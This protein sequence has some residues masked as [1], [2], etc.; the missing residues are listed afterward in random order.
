MTL[1]GSSRRSRRRAA[2]RV[3]AASGI[4]LVALAVRLVY[5]Y[6][7][8]LTHD[9]RDHL[10]L[11]RE[12]SLRPG[13]FNLPLDSPATNHPLAAVYLTALAD[14]AGGGNVF[15]IR[16]AFILLSLLGLAGLYALGASTFGP[17]VALL[18]LSLAAVDRHLVT[19]APVFLEPHSMVF[20]VPWTMLLMRRCLFRGFARDWLAAGLLFGVGYWFCAVFVVMLLPFGLYM[21]VTRRLGQVLRSRWTY[22]GVAVMLALIAASAVSESNYARNAGKVGSVGVSPRV[23]L[24]Y[25]GDLLICLKDPTWIIQ[26]HGG[27]MYFPIN[28]P[29]HWVTGLVY[30]AL[31]AASLRFRRD[32][33]VI[34]LLAAIVGV[35]IPVTLIGARE[36]WN[37]FTWASS[38]LFAAILLASFVLARRLPD[39]PGRLLAFMLVGYSSVALVWFLAGPKWGYFCPERE[40]ACVGRVL[41]LD[42]R[43]RWNP[44]RFPME[45]CV[46]EIRALTRR[47]TGRHPRCFSAWYF[48]GGFAATRAER[49]EAF[50]RAL[51]LSPNNVLVVAGQA[52][53]RMLAGDPTGARSLLER[54][55]SGDR[56]TVGLTS[57]YEMAVE[58][59]H[60]T[61]KYASAV[62]YAQKLA[63]MKPED[64]DPHRMLFVNYDAMGEHARAEACLSVYVA[65]EREGPAAAYL[66][67]AEDF[68][69]DE[70]PDKAWAFLERAIL[71]DSQR[72]EDHVRIGYQ[73]ANRL[74]DVH[75]AIEHW[76]RAVQLG[77]RAPVVYCDLALLLQQKHDFARAIGLYQRAIELAP[78]FAPAHSRL[79]VLLAGQNRMDEAEAHFEAAERLGST[80]PVEHVRRTRRNILGP[81]NR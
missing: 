58:I 18:A 19:I 29:C 47:L 3:G 46:M 32:E 9:E 11:A 12:I 54:L 24:L 78:D 70:K 30:T 25:A 53:D 26:N 6:G 60:A 4:L 77:C 2:R 55:L 22:A 50:R 31:A 41:A 68:W 27:K 80:P 42:A 20:V 36:P 34:L 1:E 51:E 10:Q 33:R 5:A 62:A 74:N 17:R 44:R 67:I 64:G 76:E 81:Y 72:A 73:L 59:E 69:E 49:E 79:A 56:G 65:R 21:L 37:E 57:V 7:L 48:R 35:S 16:V 39:K 66:S 15:A 38:T 52:R 71:A 8:P 43:S 61:G 23:A 40:R 28:V 13:S 75:R 63:A 45:R 14:R